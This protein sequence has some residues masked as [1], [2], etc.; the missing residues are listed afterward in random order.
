MTKYKLMWIEW[1]NPDNR[2]DDDEFEVLS[3]DYEKCRKIGI[4]RIIKQYENT[5]KKAKHT[6]DCDDDNWG[7]FEITAEFKADNIAEA[8]KE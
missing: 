4:K 8:K 6:A 5:G 1:H 3:F 2:F 7:E